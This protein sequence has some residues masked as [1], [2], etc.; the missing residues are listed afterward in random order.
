MPLSLRYAAHSDI[1]LVRTGNEDS[2][3]AGPR[4]LVVADGMGGAAAGEVAS[5]I[6]VSS[7]ADLDDDDL[8]L[9]I[10]GVALDAHAQHVCWLAGWW[11]LQGH[12]CGAGTDTFKL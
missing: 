12:Q 5:S 10:L 2:G 4:L 8:G 11:C 1:G 7:L 6:V 3:Y 9:G